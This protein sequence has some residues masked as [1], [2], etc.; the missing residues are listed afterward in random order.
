MSILEVTMLACFGVSWPLS[1]AKILRTKAVAG[2]SPAFLAIILLGYASGIAHKIFFSRDWVLSMYILNFCM[3][4][5][6]MALYL[7]YSRTSTTVQELNEGE[8]ESQPLVVALSEIPVAQSQIRVPR[9][10]SGKWPTAH[11]AHAKHAEGNVN[12][13]RKRRFR[14]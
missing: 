1:I 9:V 6:D 4:A 12:R 2:K 3:V 11:N 7:R 10:T 14:A 5:L 8:R 13:I